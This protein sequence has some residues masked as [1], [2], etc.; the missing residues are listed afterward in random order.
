[1]GIIIRQSIKNSVVTYVGVAIGTLNVLFLYNKF[2]STEQLGLY[3]ALTSFPLVFAGFS[4]LGTPHVGVRFFNQFADSER[5]HNGF[6]GYLLLAPF[7]GFSTFLLVYIGLKPSFESIYQQNSP[8]LIDYYWTF[9]VITFFLIYQAILDA[10]SKVHL[11]IVVPAVIR[12]IFLK[13]TNSVLALLY[14]FQYISFNQL[15]LG[16][17]LAYFLAVCFLLIYIKILGKFYLKLDFSFIRKPVFKEMYQYGLWTMLGGATATA[18]PHLEKIILPANQGG[19]AT[20]AIFNI[21]LS[22]GLVIAIPRNAIASISDPLLAES[23]RNNDIEHVGEI[24]EKSA[25]NLLI[26]GLF[27]F[28]G[29]WCNIDSI[30]Q[31]IPNSATYQQGKFVVLMVGLYSLFDMA[32]G[33]NSEILKNSPF[34]KYD[35][36]FYMVRFVI[37]LITNLILIP[38][39]SYNGAA[40]AMLI[41]VIVYNLVKFFFIKQKLNLQ[42]FGNQTV[43]VI[44]LGI[45]TYGITLLLPIFEGSFVKILINILMKSL[46]ILIIFGGGVLFL[47]ISEDLNKVVRTLTKKVF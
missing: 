18:L 9:P 31:I 13:A 37:L 23:W 35:L 28:L 19:L 26:V 1:M 25:L 33:L 11:R 32:T 47:N 40:L 34:Y 3:T 2:L 6:F 29:I 41:S 20:T 14:G 44:F 10:Y 16:I 7:V 46:T 12:E 22:I 21:A 42:P 24:Y 5:K 27:L 4:H 36:G 39:Y 43:K 30:F 8:L 45:F 38:I 17:I 15:V